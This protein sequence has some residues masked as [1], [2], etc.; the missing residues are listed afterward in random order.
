MNPLTALV[1]AAAQR[2]QTADPVAASKY[3]TGAQV[4]DPKREEAVIDAVS[5]DA[6]ARHIDAN[7]V[8]DVFRNQI[9]ATDSIEHSRFAQWKIDPAARPTT[10]PDLSTSRRAIDSLNH[11]MVSEIAA[12]WGS[13]HSPACSA[14]LTDARKSVADT[15]HLDQLYMQALDYATRPYCR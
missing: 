8:T 13:L 15:R 3:T 4:D 10:A 7:Y 14:D 6:A 5:A 12:Q 1:D 2:L 9:D 11:T